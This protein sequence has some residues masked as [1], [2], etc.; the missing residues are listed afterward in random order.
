ML[1]LKKNIENRAVIAV[2]EL[3]NIIFTDAYKQKS[4]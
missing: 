2:I 4:P 3:P 1:L